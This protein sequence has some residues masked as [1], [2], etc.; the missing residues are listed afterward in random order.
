M[1]NLVIG[2]NNWFTNYFH[3]GTKGF[4]YVVTVHSSE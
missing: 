3:G 1:D 4:V 2:E